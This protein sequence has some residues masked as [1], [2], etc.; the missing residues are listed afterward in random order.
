[1]IWTNFPFYL[2]EPA[3]SLYTE[4]VVKLL[5]ELRQSSKA[6]GSNVVAG[7]MLSSSG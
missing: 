6:L 1:M 2:A 3:S 5:F 7:V 4:L